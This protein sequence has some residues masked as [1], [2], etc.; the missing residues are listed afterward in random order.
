[1]NVVQ[2]T[3]AATRATLDA[4]QQP[5]YDLLAPAAAAAMGAGMVGGVQGGPLWSSTKT[6]SPVENAY[7]HW[8][9][10]SSEFPELA[11]SKQYVEAAKAFA[12]SPPTD[13]LVKARGADTIMYQPRNGSYPKE[14]A[15]KRSTGVG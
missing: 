13:A 1:M 8:T 12:S 5:D 11:N 15:R 2:M 3:S 10:H 9:K 7:G 14:S 4:G 6:K